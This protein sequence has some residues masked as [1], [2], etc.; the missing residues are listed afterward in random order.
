[1]TTHVPV[2]FSHRLN[3]YQKSVAKNDDTY[4][5]KLK[6]KE[7]DNNY[8]DKM[9]EGCRVFA[10]ELEKINDIKFSVGYKNSLKYVRNQEM[11]EVQKIYL[12]IRLCLKNKENHVV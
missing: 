2:F 7:L 9:E 3:D 1:M 5:A 8:K 4:D 11:F 6:E 10:S 12:A